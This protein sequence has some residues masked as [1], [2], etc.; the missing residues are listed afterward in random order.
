MGRVFFETV[1]CDLC[2]GTLVRI[3]LSGAPQVT[4]TDATFVAVDDECVYF[5][6][7]ISGSGIYSV[8]KSYAEPLADR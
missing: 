7:A 1:G 2:P 3:P 6:E 4:M 5:S 8:E